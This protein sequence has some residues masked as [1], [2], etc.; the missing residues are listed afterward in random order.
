MGARVAGLDF[1]KVLREAFE[2]APALKLRTLDLLHLVACRVAGC[3][4][5]ATLDA[6]IAGRADA[7]SRKLRRQDG[8]SRAARRGACN[9]S[10]GVGGVRYTRRCAVARC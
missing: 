9:P 3:E 8:H 1:S 4:E 7:V 6:G 5:F 10:S 2:R